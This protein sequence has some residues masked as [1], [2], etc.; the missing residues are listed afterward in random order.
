MREALLKRT[1]S[2]SHDG[3]SL[4]IEYIVIDEGSRNGR[5][6]ILKRHEGAYNLRWISEPDEG[7]GNLESK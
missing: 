3:A 5:V 2:L 4:N 1:C 6:E 7:H